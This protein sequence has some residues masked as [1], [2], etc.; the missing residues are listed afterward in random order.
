M[1]IEIENCSFGA[2]SAVNGIGGALYID[3][4]D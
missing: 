1:R 2:N 3:S 4:S